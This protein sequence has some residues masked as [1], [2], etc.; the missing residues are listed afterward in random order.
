MSVTAEQLGTGPGALRPRDRVFFYR[1]AI[2]VT[3]MVFSGFILNA[4]FNFESLSR[5]T[6]WI[7][8]HS[9]FSAA[10]YLLLINQ[11]R[12]ARTGNMA[13]HR[14]MGML[15]AWL[16]VGILASG[17]PMVLDLYNHTVVSGQVDLSQPDHRVALA[18][19][20]GRI[21]L[22][23]VLFSALFVLGL[24]NIRRPIHHKRFMAATAIQMA[25]ASLTRLFG[26]VGLA[27]PLTM[28]FLVALYAAIMV[29]DW[30]CSRRIHW[31]TLLA[32]GIFLLFPIT[33]GTVFATQWW[34]DFVVGLLGTGQV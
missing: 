11:L 20:I 30:R 26:L 21:S 25:P 2:I 8:F 28:L 17:A 1:F 31:S 34:G 24:L 13:L 23:W 9:L 22:Q 7:F 33:S 6:P 14:R 32:F 12:L 4:T 3:V 15:S 5:F 10:W 16:V 19:S 18:A 27:G 29:H